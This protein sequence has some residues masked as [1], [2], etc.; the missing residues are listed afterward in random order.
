M[1]EYM[2]EAIQHLNEGSLDHFH[3]PNTERKEIVNLLQAI[4]SR[5]ISTEEEKE[6]GGE[7]VESQEKSDSMLIY[8]IY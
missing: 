5:I 8:G 3:K 6:E 2:I 1:F 4:S 7:T